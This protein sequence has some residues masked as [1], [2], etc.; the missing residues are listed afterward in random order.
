MVF[1]CL[2]QV[3]ILWKPFREA[4]DAGIWQIMQYIFKV[5]WMK[6]PKEI[7]ASSLYI[8]AGPWCD[9]HFPVW[10][11][12]KTSFKAG[13]WQQLWPSSEHW[14]RRWRFARGHS[15]RAS[16]CCGKTNLR[17]PTQRLI[18]HRPAALLLLLRF[19]SG[20]DVP[21]DDSAED[22]RSCEATW[23]AAC[24]VWVHLND[25]ERALCVKTVAFDPLT[26]WFL[27]WGCRKTQA[28][29]NRVE[30]QSTKQEVRGLVISWYLICK[31]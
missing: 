24:R 10:H 3:G 9:S 21:A 22:F 25:T 2:C 5:S 4:R 7:P 11:S 15:K 31:K 28:N 1:T 18:S 14:E 8:H 12:V 6:P 29:T 13:Q 23:E 26:S 19:K 17:P 16:G 20:S 30:K 27:V